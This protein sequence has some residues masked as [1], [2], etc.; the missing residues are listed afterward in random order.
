MK[1]KPA[2][3]EK[4]Y[5]MFSHNIMGSFRGRPMLW[6]WK[7]VYDGFFAGALALAVVV[8]VGVS[9]IA[10]SQY[11]VAQV[12]ETVPITDT[13]P[14]PALPET[15]HPFIGLQDRLEGDTFVLYDITREK[16]LFAYNAEHAVPL[17]SITK[18]MTALV[19]HETT[20]AEE[21]VTIHP[22]AIE[23][24][25]DSGL[26]AG[27]QWNK[28]DLIG[29]TL[30]TSSNDGA[31]ALA[32]SVGSVWHLKGDET[33]V[34]YKK[35][36]A[37]VDRMNMRARELGFSTMKFQ[38][39]SGLDWGQGAEGGVGSGKDVAKLLAYMYQNTP[40][41]LA[42]TQVGSDVFVSESGFVHT[43]YNTNPYVY[44]VSGILGSK[45]GFTNLA[46]GN[47]AVV[48]DAG[49]AHPIVAVT[50]GSTREGRFKD[51]EVLREALSAYVSSG[52]YAYENY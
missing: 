20:L 23:T 30:I 12:H 11:S 7:P 4:K 36:D 19:A 38:N 29:F 31:E 32:A 5:A 22:H 34:E 10:V 35:V 44:S 52:W 1:E 21:T 27:E 6:W 50:L 15:S 42:Y 41:L 37:F 2:D 16:F 46:G 45:T 40:E 28:G 49:F 39:P 17:A 9:G 51:I 43:A 3:P 47:L 33:V 8:L 18:L 14:V 48:F 26:L 25:G 13:A 24:E